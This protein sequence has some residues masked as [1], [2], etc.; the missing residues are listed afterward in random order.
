MD[1]RA[2][3]LEESILA[4]FKQAC[5]LGRL[6]VAEHLL[7]ALE[8]SSEKGNRAGLPCHREALTN[9]YRTVAKLR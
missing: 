3:K 5:R 2:D 9:A 6:D 7:Q 4:L 1:R 8:V